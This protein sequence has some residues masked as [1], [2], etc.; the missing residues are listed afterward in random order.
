MGLHNLIEDEVSKVLH[1]VL[2]QMDVKCT[3]EKCQMDIAAVALNNLTP[4]YVVTEQ[5]YAYAKANNLNQQ[6]NADVLAAVTKAI[7]IVGNNPKHE[8]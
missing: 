1:K 5:G 6:F 8:Q 7:E 4:N 3:C 2:P